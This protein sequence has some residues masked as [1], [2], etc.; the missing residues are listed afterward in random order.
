MKRLKHKGAA[1]RG[2]KRFEKK[3]WVQCSGSHHVFDGP[4]M[5][6]QKCPNPDC[7][8]VFNTRVCPAHWFEPFTQSPSARR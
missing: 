4:L 6:E 2:Q 3:R 1:T 7:V 8:R 5:A